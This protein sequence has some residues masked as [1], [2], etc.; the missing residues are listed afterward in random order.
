M[1]SYIHLNDCLACGGTQLEEVLNLGY[2][3]LANAYRLPSDRTPEATYPL[4]MLAC[5]YCL[6]GQLSIS[7]DQSLLY[8]NYLYVSGTTLTLRRYFEGFAKE[9]STLFPHGNVLDIASND[10]TFLELLLKEGI[11]ANG[12]DPAQN[13]V[14]DCSRRGLNVVSGFWSSNLAKS[15]TNQ[16]DVVVAMNV[17]AHVRD[18]LDFLR[19]CSIALKEQG[20]VFVQTSQARMLCN[21]EFD[22]VYHE[23]HSYF[24]TTSMEHLVTR[25]G[26][27]V[28]S[29]KVVPVHG[30]SL[31]WELKKRSQSPRRNATHDEICR[32][33]QSLKDYQEFARLAYERAKEFHEVIEIQ[34]AR[35]RVV[36]LYGSAAKAHTFLNFVKYRPDLIV[37]DNSLKQGLLG[38]GTNVAIESPQVLSSVES[39]ILHVIGAWNFRDEIVTRLKR[40]RANSED[41]YLQYFPKLIYRDD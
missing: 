34:Q 15:Y 38:P 4:V 2:Q 3:P 32:P 18:P 7:V 24:N 23:H 31:R 20:R 29:V 17:L 21:G 22:T 35:G 1:T 12:I 36:A 37:D 6:H 41:T 25:A 8:R 30:Q 19:G 33:P 11:S 26:L 28:A 40:V 13:L 10:G 5:T 39:P 27:E 16:F 14:A 9:I